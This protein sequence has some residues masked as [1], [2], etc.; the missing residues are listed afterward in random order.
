[1]SYDSFL[2]FSC[3]PHP[4]NYMTTTTE[5]AARVCVYFFI[6]LFTVATIVSLLCTYRVFRI[7]KHGWSISKVWK[8]LSLLS[9]FLFI[10]DF[11]LIGDSC[12][13]SHLLIQ[14]ATT[15]ILHCLRS[16]ASDLKFAFARTLAHLHSRT[17][18]YLAL[19]LMHTLIHS[20]ST[21]T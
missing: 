4:P 1:L 16:Y 13:D 2:I 18:S 21:N 10:Y 7:S 17:H 11:N 3:T 5:D 19:S 20:F 6:S 8:S 15:C 9:L 14:Y 12:F